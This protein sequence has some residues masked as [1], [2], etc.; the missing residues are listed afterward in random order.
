MGAVVVV[1][2]QELL[3]RVGMNMLK[4][5]TP[6]ADAVVKGRLSSSPREAAY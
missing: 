6:G 1:A 5:K 3:I 2:Q 4:V